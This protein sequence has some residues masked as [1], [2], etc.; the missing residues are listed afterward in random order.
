MPR[1]CTTRGAFAKITITPDSSAAGDNDPNYRG[2][3]AVK[4]KTA[5][6]T[7]ISGDETY[8]GRQLMANVDYVVETFKSIAVGPSDR[9]TVTAGLFSGRTLNIKQVRPRQEPGQPAM[10]ELYCTERVS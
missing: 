1:C 3:A 5:W 6:I 10:Y 4:N 7:A 8:R 9:V 2:A